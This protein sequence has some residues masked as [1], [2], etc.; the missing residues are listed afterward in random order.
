MIKR[1]LVWWQKVNNPA[2]LW[3]PSPPCPPIPLPLSP[4]YICHLVS[5]ETYNETHLGYTYE[6][7]KVVEGFVDGYEYILVTKT[8]EAK[9]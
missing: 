7:G 9:I 2:I 8:K 1:F 6:G 4:K 3:P 5:R